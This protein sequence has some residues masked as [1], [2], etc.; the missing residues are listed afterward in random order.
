LNDLV[1]SG[2][3][4]I[5]RK[6]N[7]ADRETFKVLTKKAQFPSSLPGRRKRLKSRTG[8]CRN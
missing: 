3:I 8:Q 1:V 6:V 5:V 2:S 4:L 7:S